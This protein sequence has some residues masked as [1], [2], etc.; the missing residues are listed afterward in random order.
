MSRAGPRGREGATRPGT[1]RLGYTTPGGARS[2]ELHREDCRTG[3]ARLAEG[4]VGVVVTSPPYNLGIRYG[5][6]DDAAP[7]A[8]YLAWLGEVAEALRPRL[9]EEGSFFL[10]VG[11]S[12]A[13]PW[14]PF[15]V[16]SALREKF[17]LQ[18]VIHWVKSIYVENESYG[19]RTALNVGHFK[20]IRG[21]RFLNDTHEY[22][23]HLTKTGR[24]PLDR[25]AI[26]VPY[27]DAGN[28]VRW[29]GGGAGVRCRG[30]TWYV[31]YRTIQSRARDRPH[32]ASFPT[33]L[34]VM[35]LKLHGLSGRPRT[36]L[37]PFMGIGH[38]ALAAVEVGANAIGFEIDPTYFA[39]SVERL[40]AATAHFASATTAGAGDG[41]AVGGTRRTT[42]PLRRA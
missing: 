27:K 7:R 18:N 21:T 13:N 12:P 41:G 6:Y 29:K 25:L 9:A 33:E 37:D 32:P 35:C 16:L 14:G 23:F 28:A 15:E 24:V 11:S 3:L 19:A 17:E 31:P 8:E 39:T 22:L 26:G 4:S 30:N 36:V 38:T 10:N 34:A 2:V 40:R 20:P 42:T 5:A 1:V